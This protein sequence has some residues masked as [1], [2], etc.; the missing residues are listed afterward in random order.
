[1]RSRDSCPEPLVGV[2]HTEIKVESRTSKV[3]CRDCVVGS[4]VVFVVA[5]KDNF[6]TFVS[7]VE[8]THL[9][10]NLYLSLQEIFLDKC[11]LSTDVE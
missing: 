11:Q 4:F 2:E 1:M 7:L 8:D 10:T 3:G 5:R 6:A 9:S